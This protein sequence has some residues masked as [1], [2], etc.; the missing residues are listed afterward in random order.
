MILKNMSFFVFLAWNM[1]FCVLPVAFVYAASETPIRIEADKMESF[2]KE[3][4]VRFSGNVEAIQGDIKILSHVMTV[5]YE[6]NDPG[7]NKNDSAQKMKKLVATGNVKLYKGDTRGTAKT[8]EYYAKDSKMILKGDAKA[9][10]NK[11][12]VEGERIIMYL[13]EG[14]SIVERGPEKGG[15]VKAFIMSGEGP[16]VAPSAK[17][18]KK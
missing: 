8:M 5:T 17:E 13:D 11:N 10:Q 15:R 16:G 6:K 4:A 14:R 12:W 9:L 2:E 3:G 7:K 18:K 1:T